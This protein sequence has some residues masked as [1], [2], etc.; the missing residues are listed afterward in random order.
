M[1]YKT[2]RQEGIAEQIIEKSKFIAFARPVLNREEALAYFDSLKHTYKDATHHIPALVLGEQFQ[3]QWASDDGEPQGT[4]GAP[5]VHM[6]VNEEITNV[7]VMVVRYFG[8]IKLGPGGLIRAYTS[9]AKLALQA[10][11]INLVRNM[12]EM[13]LQVGYPF[14]QKIESMAA[15]GIFAIT[16]CDYS[17]AVTITFLFPES[18]KHAIKTMLADLTSGSLKILSEVCKNT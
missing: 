15:E 8:G 9:T 7:A 3:T 1:S 16:N 13:T 5:L 6:L 11:E 17:D 4:A 14:L 18:E 2:V 10:A 12:V